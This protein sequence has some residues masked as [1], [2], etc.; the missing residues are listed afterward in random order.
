M[1]VQGGQAQ[2]VILAICC[3]LKPAVLLLDEPTSSLDAEATLRAEQVRPGTYHTRHATG[4]Q[5]HPTILPFWPGCC[6]LCWK[7]RDK[8]KRGLGWSEGDASDRRRWPI[9]QL[10]TSKSAGSLN[11]CHTPV[12]RPMSLQV[13]VREPP[14][15]CRAIAWQ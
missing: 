12:A 11:L 3:A 10:G 13:M 7:G 14:G 8:I 15:S 1:P 5:L 9:C 6:L 2:R 4:M